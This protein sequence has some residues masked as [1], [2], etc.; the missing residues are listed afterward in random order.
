MWSS[1]YQDYPTD[2][3]I[4]KEKV[5]PGKGIIGCEMHEVCGYQETLHQLPRERKGIVALLLSYLFGDK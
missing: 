4:K 2:S 5:E 3:P 1:E